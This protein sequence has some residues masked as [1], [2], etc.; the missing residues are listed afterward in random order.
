MKKFYLLFLSLFIFFTSC[1]KE[2]IPNQEAS[3]EIPSISTVSQDEVF[4]FLNSSQSRSTLKNSLLSSY[5]LNDLSFEPIRNSSE[6]LAILPYDSGESNYSSRILMLKIKDELKAIVFH[7]KESPVENTSPSFTGLIRITDLEGNYISG[8]RVKKGV[9]VSK[10]VLREFK[11]SNNKTSD[12]QE[13]YNK[14]TD[15]FCNGTLE[16]VIVDGKSG[17]GSNGYINIT[18]VYM[19]APPTGGTYQEP[20][21]N[22]GG[23]GGG[24]TG[25]IKPTTPTEEEDKIYVKLDGKELCTYQRLNYA[26]VNATN[27]HNLMTQLFIEFG[28][29]NISNSDLIITSE[30]LSFSGGKSQY[31]GD[32]KFK[33]IISNM[34]DRSSIE[35]AAV[36]L[37]EM[38][39]AFL[40]KHYHL[41]NKSFAELYSMYINDSGLENYSH[42]IMKDKFLGRMAQ[43]LQDYDSSLFSNFEDYVTLAS[44]GVYSNYLEEQLAEI[45]SIKNYA[46]QKDSRC[47][48]LKR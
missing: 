23:P 5:D 38:S 1:E 48:T 19:S 27:Y 8:Y 47:T 18:Y 37:H 14:E 42:D 26:G 28:E 20:D 24:G 9:I 46:L 41:Y 40:A 16:E 36:I 2:I 6:Y 32:G 39:H 35:I 33:I 15:D 44:A 11:D 12:C 21:W 7:L 10:F 45:K 4:N 22:Y 29:G 43:T 17:G 13:N 25:Y 3:N 34:S 31:L 30:D